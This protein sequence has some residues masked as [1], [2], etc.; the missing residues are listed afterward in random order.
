MRKKKA[1]FK[2]N[3]HVVYPLQGVGQITSIVEKQF[4]GE[5]TPYYSIYI[6]ANDMV[7]M[8]PVGVAEELGIRAIVPKDVAEKALKQLSLGYEPITADWKTR[9]QMNLDLLKDGS[10]ASVVTVVRT[11]YHRS[12]LKELPINERKLYD[13]ALKILVDEVSIALSKD[14]EKVEELIH[15]KLESG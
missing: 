9:Y 6:R 11:L 1:P 10:V 5:M 13:D 8:V 15:N 14:K 2:E 7:V 3:Q 12:K 4:K